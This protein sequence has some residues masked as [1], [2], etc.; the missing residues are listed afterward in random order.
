MTL[1]PWSRAPRGDGPWQKQASYGLVH[2]PSHHSFLSHG[3]LPVYHRYTVL[4]LMKA[5]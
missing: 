5:S 4:P 1:A 3:Q 2:D